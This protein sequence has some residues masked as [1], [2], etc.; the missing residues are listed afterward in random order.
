[1]VP[2]VQR[3]D[4]E[5]ISQDTHQES[6][7]PGHPEQPVEQD[8]RRTGPGFRGMQDHRIGTSAMMVTSHR[9]AQRKPSVL[10]GVA[11]RDISGS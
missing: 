4:P 3:D 9:Q 5:P 11:G 7:V 10:N 6:K 1:M 2:Q 8:N